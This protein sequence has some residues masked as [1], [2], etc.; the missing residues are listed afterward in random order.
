MTGTMEVKLGRLKAEGPTDGV[1][2]AG[3]G[4]PTLAMRGNVHGLVVLVGRIV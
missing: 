3:S 2:T 1:P 4:S